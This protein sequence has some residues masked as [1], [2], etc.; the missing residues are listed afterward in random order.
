MLIFF[1]SD[2][3]LNMD[4]SSSDTSRGHKR[5]PSS[6]SNNSSPMHTP[7]LSRSNPDLSSIGGYSD[8]GRSDYPEHVLKIYKADQTCKYILLHR[9]CF[10]PSL[11]FTRST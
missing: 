8:D 11:I 6:S 9:V 4:D 2:P 1:F 10:P 7:H 3:N 5:M